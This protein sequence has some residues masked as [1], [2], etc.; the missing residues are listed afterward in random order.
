[1][2][3]KGNLMKTTT[4][5]STYIAFGSQGWCNGQCEPSGFH[6]WHIL[7]SFFWSTHCGKEKTSHFPWIK[8]PFLSYPTGS[9]V[10]VLS[11][12]GCTSQEVL[13]TV[14]TH[15]T[16]FVEIRRL[17]ENFDYA[18]GISIY[19]LLKNMLSPENHTPWDVLSL[20]YFT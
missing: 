7:Q 1:M 6:G 11:Y 9:L 18:G 12:P 4:Y 8:P 17:E 15:H 16:G 19:I 10:T 20:N 3:I 2:K 5:M 14:V 13:M